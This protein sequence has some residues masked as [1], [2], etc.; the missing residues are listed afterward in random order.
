MMEAAAGGGRSTNFIVG[1]RK[2]GGGCGCAQFLVSMTG[3]THS[4]Q[5][6]C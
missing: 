6:F 5:K 4:E 2:S 1:Q 3:G